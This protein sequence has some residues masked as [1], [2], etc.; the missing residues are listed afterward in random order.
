MADFNLAIVKTLE[1]EGGSKITND[2]N[3]KGGLTKYGISQRAYPTLDI[4][5]L[6]QSQAAGIYKRDYWD[7]ICGDE[8][9]SQIIAESIFDSA[10]NMGV[11]TASRLAQLSVGIAK[12]DGVIGAESV[13][14]LN[15]FDE[16]SFVS[17][18]LNAKIYRYAQI[19]NKDKSQK[20]FLLGWINRSL[21]I[22]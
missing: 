2:P 17:L 3:D 22:I 16:R 18:F 10:V 9:N 8:I 13:K 20:T 19:C 14:I 6:S 12:P 5:N 1:K 4:R 21:G 11:R 15:R 7:K